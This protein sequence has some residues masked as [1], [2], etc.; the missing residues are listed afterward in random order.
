M[1][2]NLLFLTEIKK[3]KTKKHKKCS[4][5]EAE[6]LEKFYWAELKIWRDVREI[7]QN[8]KL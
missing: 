7:Q 2:V 1:H 3:T 6:P 5:S 8:M 4:G